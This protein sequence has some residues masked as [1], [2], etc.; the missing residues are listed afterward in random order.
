M[1]AI[2]APPEAGDQR[3]SSVQSIIKSLVLGSVKVKAHV[4]SEDEREGGLRNLLNFGHSIGHAYE[5]ILTPQIL[6]GECVSIGMVL[7]A[8]L[9]RHLGVLDGGAVARLAK[10]LSSYGLPT[11]SSDPVVRRRSANKHCTV[12]QLLSVMGA[13][14]K[15]DG[16]K[17]RIVLLAGIG[18]TFK[19]EATVVS[20]RDIRVILS[21]AV[22]VEP[23]T[24]KSSNVS[25]TPPGS[26]SISNRAL[27]LAALGKGECRI[28]NLLHSDDTEVMLNAL[29]KLKGATFAWEESGQI[30]VVRGNGG[31]L[32]AHG[33]ELYLGNAGTASRFLA[34]VATLAASGTKDFSI[35]TGNER[36]K[37]RPIGPLVEALQANGAGIEFL[38]STGSLPLN[39]KAG[40]GMKGGDINL[41]ATIS[42]QYVSSLLMCAPYADKDVT[43][44]LIGGKPISQLYIDMTTAM[45][46][47]FG[48][49]VQKSTTEEHTYHIPRGRYVNPPEYVIESDA[50]SATYPLAIAAIT[51]T[52]CTVPNIGSASLQGDARFAVDVLRP[53]GCTVEQTKTST[54]VTGPPK[55]SLRP[56][57]EIDMEPMTDAFLTASI[58]AAVAQNGQSKSTTR[59]TGIANQRVKECNRI[60]AMEDELAKFGV[61]CHQLDDGIEI[62]GIP[63]TALRKPL[64]GVHCYDDHRVAMSFSVLG[65]V[66][67][68]GTLIQERQCV[69]KTWPG[70]WDTLRQ[71][72][73]VELE[74]VDPEE[75]N[76][77][78]AK[79]AQQSDKSILII[80]MR[81]AGKTTTG[82][83]AA[84]LLGWQFVDLDTLLEE[85]AGQ[86]IPKIIEAS[87]WDEFRRLELAVLQKALHEKGKKHIL[88]CGGGV[89][90]I[91]EAR[92]LLTDFHRAGGLVIL[93]QRD[94]EDIMSFLQIDKTRPAYVDNLR[95]VWLRRRP[96]YLECSNYQYYSTKAGQV[97]MAPPLDG[98]ERFLKTVTGRRQALSQIKVKEQSYF[99]SLTVPDVAAAAPILEEVA[100]GSDAVE[101]R[102]DL[103]EDPERKGK[104]PSMEFVASQVAV[105]RCSSSLP[106]IFTVRSQSQGG[107]MPD[108]AHEDI[109]NLLNLAL[110]MGVE[111]LDLEISLPEDV[112]RS[113]SESKRNTKIIASHHDPDNTLSW[114]S[115][116]WVPH[117]NKA[118]LYGDIV[119][120]V[121]VAKTQSSNLSLLKFRSWALTAHPSIP[122]IAINMGIEGQLSR[123]QN[124][125]LTP[126]SHSALPF[127]AAPGQLSASEI[128]TALSLHGVIKPRNFYLFGK[129]ISQS[130]SP[131]MHNYL[132]REMGLP[133]QYHLHE[134]DDP[135]TL[136]P[137]IR[138]PNFGGASVTIPLKLSIVDLLDEVSPAAKTIGAVNT[139]VVDPSR[140]SPT[141]AGKPYLVG[142]NTDW[143]GMRV[144]LSNAGATISPPNSKDQKGALV[145]GGGGTARAAIYTLNQMGY[146]PIHLLG[147][148]REKL[149]TVVESFPAEDYDISLITTREDTVNIAKREHASPIAVAIGTIPADK[150]IDANVEAL[151]DILF[152]AGGKK[153]E[154]RILLE[155][156][157]KPAITPLMT[158]AEKSGWTTVK[159]LEVLAGQG[160]GQ[161][162]LW[163]RIK[164]LLRDARVSSCCCR[165]L[166]RFMWNL[167]N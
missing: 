149:Q 158:M 116:S 60:K 45:M 2:R 85:T 108:D 74:G 28:K 21:P 138:N 164:P 157:Y 92:Q 106:I 42:S 79:N 111:F 59:I 71:S 150:P 48:I 95:D 29:V 43:L 122:I 10:C 91:P 61:K 58:L 39:V 107:K 142:H 93:V 115:G 156:A 120:L 80:G 1:A 76:Q 98:L 131:A 54:T 163:T 72:F 81:G 70:W 125:F 88:A 30:L 23:S 17:K 13:D 12:N 144:V 8:A 133:H 9:A 26:K 112:L 105:L 53:M 141:H 49:Q 11:S 137:I 75:I 103:L 130:K 104:P 119:K 100:V 90:E 101:L 114:S 36:M 57:E 56:I 51:G 161:F 162:E 87:G 147:R 40:Q 47:S 31:R 139:I 153:N 145:I 6:H 34:T 50:S 18:R 25:C 118:L 73:V 83:L 126:V 136:E 67:P 24:T 46:A 32:E 99:V 146:S 151:L 160:V 152:G 159:G 52:T 78:S 77:V 109:H 132:F 4:V 110:R 102:V 94:I 16:K 27:V 82:G 65:T 96:W 63:Y 7:E 113:I 97:D 15:N 55:G 37:K 86:T 20:D 69:G 33:E 124:P 127:K 35:L 5:G 44:R 117:Y 41:A 38:E 135:S 14:K 134:A 64:G 155:M 68:H 166:F 89:V 143:T 140:S 22:I 148:S 128:R 129:P 165:C 3:L 121:G 123:I 66:A 62:N 154:K 84:S 19:R 167:A